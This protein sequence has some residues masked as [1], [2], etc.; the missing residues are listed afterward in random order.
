M[1]KA[2][3]MIGTHYQT[4]SLKMYVELD[5]ELIEALCRKMTSDSWQITLKSKS[6]FPEAVTFTT[7]V[8]HTRLTIIAIFYALK[9]IL[10]K[11]GQQ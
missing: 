1:P 9:R 7:R 5:G 11:N 2:L 4:G 10:E 6:L 8:D 3:R